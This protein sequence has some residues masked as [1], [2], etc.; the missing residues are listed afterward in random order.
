MEI[1]NKIT[2]DLSNEVENNIKIENGMY[3]HRQIEKRDNKIFMRVK[4]RKLFE[5]TQV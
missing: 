2:Y 3:V 4:S 1:T 5:I